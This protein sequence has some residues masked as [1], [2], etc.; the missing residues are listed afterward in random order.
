MAQ[1]PNLDLKTLAIRG[2]LFNW[3]GRGCSIVITFFLT[4]FLVQHL[5]DER[6]GLWSIAFSLLGFYALADLGL[7]GTSTKYIAEKHAK[8]C[9]GDV[10]RIVVTT[11]LIYA[12]LGV[13]VLGVGCALATFLPSQLKTAHV[14]ASTIRC[15]LILTAVT[16]AIRLTC[17]PFGAILAAFA[18]YDL[19]NSLA[20]V[21]QIGSA[22][23]MVVALK[24]GWGLTG[25]AIGTLI[26]G[27]ATQ[28]GQ[29][30][31]AHHVFTDLSL[32]LRLFD[33]SLISSLSSFSLS[34]IAINGAR[35]LTQYGI[36][37]FMG[38]ILGPALVAVYSIADSVIRKTSMLTK[39]VSSVVMPIASRL[40]A[41]GDRDAILRMSTVVS[42]IM[43]VSAMFVFSV[44][45][46]HGRDIIELWIGEGYGNKVYLVLCVLA[47]ANVATLVSGGLPSVLTGMGELRIL[48][49]LMIVDSVLCVVLSLLLMNVYG[50]V[51]AAGGILAV[52][53]VTHSVIL[54]FVVCRL[55]ERSWHRFVIETTGSAVLGVVPGV[56]VLAGLLAFFPPQS[57]FQ[58]LAE[59]AVAAGCSAVTT[60]FLCIPG[61]VRS[62]VVNIARLP[63]GI[64]R[65]AI[66]NR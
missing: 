46:I 11:L 24:L 3:I 47:A 23:A 36:V 33:R 10:N 5:G 27:A 56:L 45:L 17:Q 21:S 53:L 55:V 13:V 48:R 65:P 16:F 34:L 4:P 54:P 19:T 31:L 49:R 38:M 2:V 60:F 22:V 42:R 66:R 57:L 15:V 39:G 29:F 63:S 52:R 35:Q 7:R 37:L 30:L 41:S 51:G 26:V 32:S 25:M 28:C 8:G 61:D 43:Q 58:V 6:Y 1:E 20:V 12:L 40:D 64:P 9:H 44:C 18:R 62:K 14:D 59:I 50:V